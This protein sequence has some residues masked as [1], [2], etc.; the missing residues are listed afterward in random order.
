MLALSGLI[1]NSSC[2]SI[3][4]MDNTASIRAALEIGR[5]G[6]RWWRIP[7][8]LARR[9]VA[10]TQQQQAAGVKP[11]RVARNIGIGQGTLQ[12]ILGEQASA[13]LLPVK[14]VGPVARSPHIV[15]RG[16]HGVRVE[17]LDLAELAELLRALSC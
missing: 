14:V 16:G 15:V 10:F 12:R 11:W 6:N 5:S 2:D 7:E 1:F 13:A 8:E 4:S 17:G 9:I 3:A